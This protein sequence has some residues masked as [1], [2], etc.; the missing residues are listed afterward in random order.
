MTLLNYGPKRCDYKLDRN[1]DTCVKQ[2]MTVAT[3]QKRGQGRSRGRRGR[4]L[5]AWT[6]VSKK[7]DTFHNSR[8]TELD[9]TLST[10]ASVRRSGRNYAG[11]TGK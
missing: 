11:T 6:Y 8:T 7:F 10:G 4:V 3:K 5:A 1:Q 2:L 9:Q